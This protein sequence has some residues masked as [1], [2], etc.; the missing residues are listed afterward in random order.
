MQDCPINKEATMSILLCDGCDNPIDT[1][2]HPEAYDEVAERWWCWNCFP[3]HTCEDCEGMGEVLVQY[4]NEFAGYHA[5]DPIERWIECEACHGGSGASHAYAE[6]DALT[7]T[8]RKQH[9][10]LDR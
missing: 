10:N 9:A 3:D 5:T 6:N 2:A 7:K 4:L 8:R 1:D